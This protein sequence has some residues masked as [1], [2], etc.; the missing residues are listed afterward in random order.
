MIELRYSLVIEATPDPNFFAFY[1]TELEG[2]S[3]VGHSVED[4]LYKAKWGMK[5]HVEL[6]V[7]QGL[8]VP[9]KNLSPVVTIRNEQP[10]TV[11]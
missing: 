8:P 7:E 9:P 4:C 11:A 5:E 3:G 2:F 6:L 1:S 10:G